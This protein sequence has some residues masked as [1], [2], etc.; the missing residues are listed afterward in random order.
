M[1]RRSLSPCFSLNL[2]RKG[3]VNLPQ[4]T[5][6][7]PRPDAIK[8]EGLFCFQIMIVLDCLYTMN[9]LRDWI[10]KH[11]L[12][13]FGERRMLRTVVPVNDVVEGIDPFFGSIRGHVFL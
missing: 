8:Y 2:L 6:L 12:G 7:R 4:Q 9:E 5:D 3:L 1:R 10:P 13:A 11:V